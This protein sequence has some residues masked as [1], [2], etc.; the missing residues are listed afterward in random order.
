M[1]L[2]IFLCLCDIIV[3]VF[4]FCLMFLLLLGIA[5][6]DNEARSSAE[7]E[8]QASSSGGRWEGANDDEDALVCI[9]LTQKLHKIVQLSCCTIALLE[10]LINSPSPRGCNVDGIHITTTG[11]SNWHKVTEKHY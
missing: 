2:L 10:L 6:T 1:Q 7:E 9:F 4:Y 3:I 5:A 11:H 8:A